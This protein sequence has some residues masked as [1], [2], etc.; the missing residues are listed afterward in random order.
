MEIP[1]NHK[2]L[3]DRLAGDLQPITPMDRPAARMV[4]WMAVP[5]SFLVGMTV[6]H[7]RP[8]LLARLHAPAFVLEL[9]FLAASAGMATWLVFSAAAPDR[10]ALAPRLWLTLA[11][12]AGAVATLLGA[13]RGGLAVDR[14][15][16]ASGARCLQM[17]LPLAALPWGILVL[18]LRRGAPVAP[19]AAGALA[20]GAAF[21]LANVAMRI[22]CAQDASLHVLTWHLLPA[23][24]AAL[25]SGALGAIWFGRWALDRPHP[26]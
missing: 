4:R 12:V 22:S 5:G 14:E 25:L 11:L 17:T 6:W 8:D 23:G 10:G 15:F 1:R 19:G 13:S 16:V 9:A 21:L 7:V 3:V 26:R 20:G 2:T 24:V 18:A